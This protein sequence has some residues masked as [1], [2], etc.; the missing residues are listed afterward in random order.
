MKYIRSRVQKRETVYGT[1]CS[2]GS[3]ISSEIIAG[4]GYDWMLLDLEHAPGNPITLLQQ[5]QGAAAFPTVP[6]V[7]IPA[8]DQIYCKWA[9]D[10]GA[11]GIMFPNIDDAAQA[12]QAVSFMRYTPQGVRGVGP[13]TRASDYGR[14]F[15]A[16]AE[17]AQHQ[18]LGVMQIESASAVEH[19]AAIA[20]VQGVDVLFVG[21]ADLG[22]ALEL[23][24]RFADKRF[25]NI[26]QAI[27]DAAHTQDKAAGILLPSPE[28]VPVL[29]EMGYTFLAMGSDSGLLVQALAD[30]LV[31]LRRVS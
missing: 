3:S 12:E 19:C 20:A 15:K 28:Q 23:P 17:N 31:A 11:S 27:A 9:L 10:L 29:W 24:G 18:L 16:Y 1:W 6:I 4:A 22:A 7:R 5:L 26:L 25:M 13:A 8:L 21:P 30:N 2:L 14:D